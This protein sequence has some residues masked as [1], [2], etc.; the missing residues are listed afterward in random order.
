MNSKETYSLAST[1]KL[2]NGISMPRIHLGVYMTSGNETSK[3]VT[4]AL[5]AGYRGFDSAEWYAN[6]RE[7]GSAITSYLSSSA[8]KDIRLR[9]EDIWFT[10]K[11]KTNS[12]YDATR[13]AIKRSLQRSGLEYLDLYLLHS[14]YGGREKRRECWRAVEDAIEEGVVRCG[15]VSNFGVRH[16]S[17]PQYSPSCSITLQ[18]IGGILTMILQLQELLDSKPRIV[19]AVNQI[20]VHPFNTQE[21]ITSFCHEH[22][23]VIEAYAPLARALRMRHPKIVELSKKYNCEPA[24]LLVRWS[25]QKGYVPLP[26][27]VQKGRIVSNAKV[28]GF[29]IEEEDMKVLDGLDEHLVTDWDPTDAD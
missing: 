20:E 28:E 12:S 5:E 4:H 9:R 25:L 14:P 15:G 23:I 18:W 17:F 21:A 26:K 13:K 2:N 29:E 8:N 11:L 16:V 19:P 3:A 22:N 24:Q 1:I 27:S 7:V 6:E 10:T